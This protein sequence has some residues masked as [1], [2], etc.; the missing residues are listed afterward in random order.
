M[1]G[2][3]EFNLIKA[4]WL[5]MQLVQE[6]PMWGRKGLHTW[7]GRAGAVTETAWNCLFKAVTLPKFIQQVLQ[8][9]GF[10]PAVSASVGEAAPS[11][12]FQPGEGI[13]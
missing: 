6:A 11:P 3:I 4:L 10:S 9:L 7:D 5:N 1:E 2:G 12:P 8:V 13:S